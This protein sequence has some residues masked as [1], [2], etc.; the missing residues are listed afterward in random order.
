MPEKA[1]KC[2][3]I[4]NNSF[5]CLYIKISIYRLNIISQHKGAHT[6]NWKILSIDFILCVNSIKVTKLV[7]HFLYTVCLKRRN[8][9]CYSNCG[10]LRVYL[11]KLQLRS[12]WP[13]N[14]TAVCARKSWSILV[15]ST[16][17]QLYGCFAQSCPLSPCRGAHQTTSSVSISLAG[18]RQSKQS[19]IIQPQIIRWKSFI[20]VNHANLNAKC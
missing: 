15:S 10:C 11:S 2:L 9:R 20:C 5:S 14:W 18:R 7:I 4:K 13:S 16:N 6:I 3:N 17:W 8:R 12:L 19:N 1:S